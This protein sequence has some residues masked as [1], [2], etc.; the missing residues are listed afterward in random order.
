MRRALIMMLA[1][2]ILAACGE[3]E[4]AAPQAPAAPEAA[5]PEPVPTTATDL[6]GACRDVVERM[7][8]Q[9][10]DVVTFKAAGEGR[11]EVSW[12]A[13]V[14]GGVLSFECRADGDQVGLFRDGR[15][16]SV[17]VQMAAPAA[18][19]EAR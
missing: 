11:A 10:G 8:G 2:P 7:F 16:M 4:K 18:K 14:D 12:P 6:E 13:P 15:A 3:A 9:T 17:D 1:L 19:Q 5:A